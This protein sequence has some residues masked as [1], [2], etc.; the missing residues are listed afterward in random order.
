MTATHKTPKRPKPIA[1]WTGPALPKTLEVEV[2]KGVQFH[3]I[4]KH[5][6]KVD[7]YGFLHGVALAWHKGRLFASP[8]HNKGSEAQYH[9][10][11]CR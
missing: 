5:E 9:L 8:G 10:D 7:G 11:P 3:V 6:R 2:L 4:K 1:L